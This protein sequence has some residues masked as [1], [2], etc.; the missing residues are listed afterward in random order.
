METGG[1]INYVSPLRISVTFINR[2]EKVGRCHLVDVMKK[3]AVDSFFK[4][5]FTHRFVK[6]PVLP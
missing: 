1:N 3:K 4:S 2:H 5:F 6:V